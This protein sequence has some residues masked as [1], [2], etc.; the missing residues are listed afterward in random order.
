M[1]P[2]PEP[3]SAGNPIL[4][5]A[6]P[7]AVTGKRNRS[8]VRGGAWE[9]RT[10]NSNGDRKWSESIELANRSS[11]AGL[12]GSKSD[13]IVDRTAVEVKMGRDSQWERVAFRVKTARRPRSV[14]SH[15]SI[16]R[17]R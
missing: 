13:S 17:L 4:S 12:A 3:A 16:S 11:Y 8:S 15:C 5:A 7:G 9:K 2:G 1:R 10:S 6:P 14:G